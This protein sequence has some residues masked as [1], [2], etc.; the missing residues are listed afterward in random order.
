MSGGVRCYS[1]I[2][3]AMDAFP[4][5]EQLQETACRLFRTFTSGQTWAFFL[6]SVQL[7]LDLTHQRVDGSNPDCVWLVSPGRELLQH[8]GTQWCPEGGAQSLSDVP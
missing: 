1:V 3:A 6:R 8:P 2:M 7:C 5:V 4:E